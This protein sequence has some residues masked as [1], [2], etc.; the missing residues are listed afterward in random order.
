MAKHGDLAG[1]TARKIIDLL[2]RLIEE[3][4]HIRLIPCL[5]HAELDHLLGF[6]KVE[7]IEG[8]LKADPVIK[9]FYIDYLGIKLLLPQEHQL[10]KLKLVGLVV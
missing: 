5:A 7:R 9:I 1:I 8:V 10:Q 6:I 3:K 2:Y 4:A